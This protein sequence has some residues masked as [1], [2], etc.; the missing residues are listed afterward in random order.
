M[1]GHPFQM[2]MFY[3]YILESN[4]KLGEFYRGHTDDLKRRV[5]EHN[6]GKCPHTSKF[7]PWKVKFYAAFETLAL[8]QEFEKYLKTGSGCETKFFIYA[9]KGSGSLR[10]ARSL[11]RCFQNSTNLPLL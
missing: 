4:I 11:R 1:A 7:K 3:A 5:A 6:A 8:T 9:A 2:F 10:A